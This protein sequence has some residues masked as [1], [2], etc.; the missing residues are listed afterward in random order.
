[1]CD[2]V[3]IAYEELLNR[4]SSCMLTMKNNGIEE[5][6]PIS[7]IDINCWEWPQG[8]GIYGLYKYYE[9][10]GRQDILDFLIHWY[11]ERMEEGILEKNVNTTAPMLTLTYIYEITRKEEY[12][13]LIRERCV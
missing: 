1:M 6:F 8:V 2:N 10:S 5:R 3:N 13:D 11:D 9:T 7:L 12:L 4:V